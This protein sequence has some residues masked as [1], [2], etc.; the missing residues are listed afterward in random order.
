MEVFAFPSWNRTVKAVMLSLKVA[1]WADGMGNFLVG[2]YHL[3]VFSNPFGRE[4]DS[5]AVSAA[6]HF[7][8]QHFLA[9]N[10]ELHLVSSRLFL[11]P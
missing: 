11:F 10:F 3:D 6:L 9:V 7:L 8:F 5:P 1:P 4:V 2:A